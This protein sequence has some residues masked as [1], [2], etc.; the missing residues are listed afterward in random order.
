MGEGARVTNI[1]EG[2]EYRKAC[3]VLGLRLVWKFAILSLYTKNKKSTSRRGSHEEDAV[4][5]TGKNQSGAG[6]FA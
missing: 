3:V 2:M 5:S 4:K 6:C 1:R